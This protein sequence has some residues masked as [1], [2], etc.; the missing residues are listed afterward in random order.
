VTAVGQ[1]EGGG[2]GCGVI[3]GRGGGVRRADNNSITIVI[4]CNS[5]CE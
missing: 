3:R 5:N 1:G 4:E 2:G